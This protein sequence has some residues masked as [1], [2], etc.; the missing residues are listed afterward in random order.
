VRQ[1][2]QM[3][4]ASIIN[5]NQSFD[6]ELP[7]EL[8]PE[9]AQAILSDYYQHHLEALQGIVQTLSANNNTKI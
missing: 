2:L 4:V 9:H 3:E 5:D 1:A 6:K 7:A 8:S